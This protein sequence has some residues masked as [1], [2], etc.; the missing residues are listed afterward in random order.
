MTRAERPQ[1]LPLPLSLYPPGGDRADGTFGYILDFTD[2]LLSFMDTIE[3]AYPVNV[4]R[5]RS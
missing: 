1:L 4:E 5:L 2:G 3:D